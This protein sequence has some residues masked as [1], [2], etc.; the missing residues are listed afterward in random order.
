MSIQWLCS[1]CR[2]LSSYSAHF[3]S[4]IRVHLCSSVVQSRL[5]LLRIGVD[6]SRAHRRHDAE[7]SIVDLA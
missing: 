1:I 6:F 2:S 4:L 5:N 3:F 7:Y